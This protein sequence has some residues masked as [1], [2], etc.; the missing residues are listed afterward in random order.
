MES[1]GIRPFKIGDGVRVYLSVPITKHTYYTI[2]T[3]IDINPSSDKPYLIRGWGR[4]EWYSEDY[5][6]LIKKQIVRG[7][8]R[9]IEIHDAAIE[10]IKEASAKTKCLAYGDFTK[11]ALW[12]DKTMIAKAC[13]VLR[14]MTDDRLGDSF[15]D[16]FKRRLEEL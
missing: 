5:I 7:G 8:K 14:D 1:G 13:D 9:E 2:G 3:I 10:Y 11:G 12:A 16:D 6:R 4:S 15:M